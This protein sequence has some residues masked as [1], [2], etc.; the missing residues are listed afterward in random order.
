MR[1]R[2]CETQHRMRSAAGLPAA[3][4]SGLLRAVRLLGV[5]A[6]RVRPLGSVAVSWRGLVGRCGE[7]VLEV[8]QPLGCEVEGLHVGARHPQGSQRRQVQRLAAAGLLLLVIVLG[9]EQLLAHRRLL[10]PGDVVRPAPHGGGAQLLAH[11]RAGEDGAFALEQAAGDLPLPRVLARGPVLGRL[12]GIGWGLPVRIGRQGGEVGQEPPGGVEALAGLPAAYGLR[13]ADVQAVRGDGG[14]HDPSSRP[15]ARRRL[16]RTRARWR[17][18]SASSC[19][20]WKRPPSFMT[21][22]VAVTSTSASAMS[23]TAATRARNAVAA[24]RT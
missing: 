13:L 5:L 11:H 8:A 7:G 14:G 2:R 16:R 1:H 9:R 12:A 17:R 21:N 15:G 24:A 23:T 3:V 4:R 18:A 22:S 6:H 10:V 20:R 19:R